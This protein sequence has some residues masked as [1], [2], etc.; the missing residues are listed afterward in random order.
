MFGGADF[1]KLVVVGMRCSLG[2]NIVSIWQ[3]NSTMKALGFEFVAYKVD[4]WAEA[5]SEALQRLHSAFMIV[6]DDG[7][8][9]ETNRSALLKWARWDKIPNKEE[10][11][12]VSRAMI[13]LMIHEKKSLDP[14]SYLHP[15]QQ[16]SGSEGR[17][18]ATS[19]S[20]CLV[21]EVVGNK[22]YQEEPQLQSPPGKKE[23][24]PNAKKFLC[25]AD[26]TTA[27]PTNLNEEISEVFD[28][29]VDHYEGRHKTGK[30]QD[31]MR[32]QSYR[33]VSKYV[34]TLEYKL[35]DTNFEDKL[36]HKLGFGESNMKKIS[37]IL[38]LG[39]CPKLRAIEANPANEVLRSFIKIWGVGPATAAN[40]YYQLGFRSIE[41]IRKNPQTLSNRQR[42]GLKYYEELQERIPRQ[43]VDR[44]FDSVR[45]IAQKIDASVTCYLCGSHRRGM[46]NS[47]DIDVLISLPPT[48]G[49]VEGTKCNAVIGLDGDAAAFAWAATTAAAVAANDSGSYSDNQ[50]IHSREQEHAERF[51][52]NLLDKLKRSG[53][54]TDHLSGHKGDPDP[55]MGGGWGGKKAGRATGYDATAS[56]ASYMGV[57]V[58]TSLAHGA[59]HRRIDIKIYP[60][61]QLPYALLYFTGTDLFNRSMRLYAKKIRSKEATKGYTLSDKGLFPKKYW[62][63]KT[64]ECINGDCVAGLY[65]ERDVMEYLGLTWKEPHERTGGVVQGDHASTGGAALVA[66]APP[67]GDADGDPGLVEVEDGYECVETDSDSD[68]DPDDS[69]DRNHDGYGTP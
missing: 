59:K 24:Y 35:T 46:L 40:L 65:T 54:L 43:E 19:A 60:P 9:S 17:V 38:N 62:H 8:A 41:A 2:Q 6:L 48:P 68:L 52:Q 51:L 31:Q 44:I 61:W 50:S 14:R 37:S 56:R 32:L 3:D 58:D 15:L 1:K 21:M 28:K 16:H 67:E 5:S 27:V 22:Q 45:E 66:F 33:T 4:P 57:G 53:I 7:M 13:P 49:G 47:G 26:P 42:I 55:S 25:Q 20:A 10:V 30:I 11:Y 29:L 34:K 18:E 39:Y 23:Y 69:N 64:G 36:E 12:I 63:H